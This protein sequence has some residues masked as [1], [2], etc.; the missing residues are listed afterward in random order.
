M[1]LDGIIRLVLG[2]GGL[3]LAIIGVVDLAHTI[4]ITG[5]IL[6]AV[7]IALILIAKNGLRI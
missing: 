1:T 3:I 6:L 4:W 7:G 5:G 2:I